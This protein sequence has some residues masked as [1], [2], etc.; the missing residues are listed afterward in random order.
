MTA[1]R[2]SPIFTF[3]SSSFK[4]F[5]QAGWESVVVEYDSSF[6]TLTTQAIGPLLD[7]VGAARGVRLLDVACGPGYVA[8]AAAKRGALVVGVDFSA[9]MVAHAKNKNPA[10]EFRQAD[11]ENLPFADSS[12]DAVVM[13][14]GVLHLA[15]PDRALAEARRAL[16]AGGKFAF[17][18]W[19]KPAETAGFGITLGAV[20][21]HGDMNIGLPEGPP[22]FRF[23]DWEECRRS[24]LEAGF[25]DPEIKK[26]PQT[27]RLPSV[28]ALFAA[29]R[30]AT[31]RTAG[32]LGRQNPDALENIRVM[33]TNAVRLYEKNGDVELPM[34][35]ILA[36][37]VKPLAPSR[38]EKK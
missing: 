13:N 18:A 2:S 23:S 36:S 37:A 38:G 9:P 22:F 16:R 30:N 32:L 17:T 12:F 3:V 34:P 28:D 25:V 4:D 19:A 11:A 1:S 24:L 14:F 10:I 7:S 31:V 35:A 15:R 29:M 8:A 26:I 33:M 21:T 6:G 20:Q 27:W 5:E